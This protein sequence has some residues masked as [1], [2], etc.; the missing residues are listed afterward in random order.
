MRSILAAVSVVALIVVGCS[1]DAA[2]ADACETAV[3]EGGN[4]DDID[5]QNT[6]L[7]AAIEV[8]DSY[9]ALASATEEFPNTLGGQDLA[10]VVTER[11]AAG[12]SGPACDGIPG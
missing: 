7:D 10:T 2:P 8:C 4:D 12:V 1:D 3:D 9:D 5:D 11:C 6:N